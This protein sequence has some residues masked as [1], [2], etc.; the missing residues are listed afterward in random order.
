MKKYFL[1]SILIG[2]FFLS[3]A[4]SQELSKLEMKEINKQLKDLKKQGYKEFAGD[5]T[6]KLQLINFYKKK[7]EE[8]D[9]GNKKYLTATGVAVGQTQPA[10][11]ALAIETAK[12]TLAGYI[13]NEINIKIN[14]KV[15]NNQL[16][17]KD[18]ESLTKLVS[19]GTNQIIAE[20][21]YVRPGFLAYR[22]IEGNKMEVTANLYYSQFEANEAAKKALANKARKEMEDEADELIDEIND[23]LKR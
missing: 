1:V 19:G 17:T 6:M 4:Y 2:A 22:T 13:T 21:S 23:L 7:G 8:D 15:V 9:R 12:G 10:A 11:Q 20:M 5:Y 18:A 14:N 16:N 3:A